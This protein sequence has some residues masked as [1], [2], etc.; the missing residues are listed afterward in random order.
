MKTKLT[1][2]LAAC[3]L[4][5]GL[6]ARA[7]TNDL[8]SALQQGLFEEEA[9]RNLPAAISA[10]EAV[11]RQ[12]EKDRALAAT[13]VFRLGEC[14]RK[15][16]QTNE[17]AAQYER[18]LRDFGDQQQLATLS[19][20]NL[21]GMGMQLA[22]PAPTALSVTARM[23]QKRLLEV[24]IKL[25]EQDVAEAKK[26]FDSGIVPQGEVRAKEREVL[27]LR[28]QIAALDVGGAGGGEADPS[29]ARSQSPEA[30]ELERIQ[31]LLVRLKG[32][33][34]SQLRKMLPALVP[35]ADFERLE[36]QLAQVEG[37]P[38]IWTEAKLAEMRTAAR[39]R[40][41]EVIY[42]LQV[43]ASDFAAEVEKQLRANGANPL[44]SSAKTTSVVIDDEETEIRRLQKMIQ[45][46][47]D[48]IN[49]PSGGEGDN[50]TP[51]GRAANKGQ[52]RVAQF[53]LDS[54]A[55]VNRAY[56]SRTPLLLAAARGHKAMIELLL[57]KGA[58]VGARDNY[59]KTA[60]HIAAE[61]GFQ[62]TA[63]AL[64]AGKADVNARTTKQETPL[65]LAVGAGHVA[66]TKY[67]LA[68]GADADAQ[69]TNGG[70]ALMLAAARGHMETLQTLLAAGAKPNLKNKVGTTA[71][72]GAA[73]NR[74]LEAVKALLAAKADPNAGGLLPLHFAIHTKATDV[75]QALLEAG[76]DANRLGQVQWQVQ[77]GNTLYN[78]GTANFLVTPLF[79]A[80]REGNADAVKPLLAH[81]ADPN[82]LGPDRLPLILQATGSPAILEALL[83]AGAKPNVDDGEGRT[84][85]IT[86]VANGAAE[87][88]RVLLT[89]G[90]DKEVRPFGSTPLLIAVERG[91]QK[92]A[93]ALLQAG[94]E[95]NARTTSEGRTALHLATLRKDPTLTSLLLTN[96]ADVNARDNSGYTPLDYAKG[97]SAARAPGVGGFAPGQM[98]MPIRPPGFPVGPTTS[99]PASPTSITDLLR[100][101]GA[102]DELP[103]FTTLRVTR[104]GLDKPI[105]VFRQQTN[106]WNR[107]TLLETI[108]GLY[109]QQGLVDFQ[110]AYGALHGQNLNPAQDFQSRLQNIM[111]NA[112]RSA[113]ALWFPDL[114]RILVHRPNRT[115][116]GKEQEFKV[117]LLN[118]TNGVDCTKDLPLEFG[119]VVEIPVRDHALS[120]SPSALSV[121]EA[122]GML[123][124]LQRKVRL[125]VRGQSRELELRPTTTE[126]CLSTALGKSEAK[127]QLLSSSDLTRVK[128]TRKDPATGQAKEFTVDVSKS[129]PPAADLWLRDGDVIEV[130]EKSASVF[131]TDPVKARAGGKVL[132]FGAVNTQFVSWPLG[133]TLSLAEA[134]LKAGTTK[135]ANAKKVQL[136]RTDPRTQQK[137]SRVL[138]LSAALK[139]DLA[140]DLPLVDGDRITV[141]EKLY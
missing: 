123:G 27:I 38:G 130:P 37:V 105:E 131:D 36:R 115:P 101:H 124:C 75:V 116:G 65:H 82:G 103:D 49:A 12:F 13:A 10:Y 61:N 51:L 74:L 69:D 80:I 77:V 18:I 1:L 135:F 57:A 120:E 44:A 93:E 53:L 111:S 90:A 138:D 34:F 43:K 139:G 33:D 30:R 23:E 15:Q 102:L 129:L 62:A 127:S 141:P 109:A 94:A 50:F 14:Y 88:V 79:V 64:V 99:A 68:K 39:V 8:S 46:S 87:S 56:Q 112:N 134:I 85:L 21:A 86:A 31:G 110:Q 6:F 96:K 118:A 28:Q 91:D 76:A 89:H 45:N 83:Q 55:E 70:T 137:E 136:V 121:A 108:L 119:D 2:T 84:P 3:W 63:E 52:L 48:L 107:F 113:N 117:N 125:T 97:A 35:D 58:D 29:P 9:N 19:R 40:G 126:S 60:L 78:S 16:G 133:Q 42:A 132:L 67:L 17:A 122:A 26:Q 71:M 104:Q 81:K 47:P 73:E 92:S 59:G 66:M 114:S 24:Q 72:L 4:A 32:I 140:D 54:G 11:A 22:A 7:A 5:T 25:V 98:P 95:V 106:N 128:V 20:Q 41:E 100:E